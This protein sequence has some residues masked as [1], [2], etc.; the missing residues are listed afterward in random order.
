MTLKKHAPKVLETLPKEDLEMDVS[1]SEPETESEAGSES[2]SE[3]DE[4]VKF[5]KPSK[6]AIYNKEAR[7]LAFYTQGLEGT[8]EAFAKIQT[9]GIPFLRPTDYYA[10]HGENQG[11]DFI[12]KEKNRGGCGEKKG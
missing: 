7:E 10:P 11:S 6:T 3:G 1:E 8:R 5:S 12:L 9:M 4:D 2:K